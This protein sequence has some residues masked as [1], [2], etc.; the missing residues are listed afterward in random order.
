MVDGAGWLEAG[1][2]ESVCTWVLLKWGFGL[3]ISLRHV[4]EKDLA[5]CWIRCVLCCL[6]LVRI[7][8]HG[9]VTVQLATRQLLEQ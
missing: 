1:G 2:V 6:Y 3:G 4:G 9:Q 5:R 7:C 8:S